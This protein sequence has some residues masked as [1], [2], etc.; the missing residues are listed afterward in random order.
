MSNLRPFQVVLLA[1]FAIM[2][3]GATILL[4]SFQA[5]SSQEALVYGSSVSV[6]GTL[7]REVMRD[8]FDEITGQV[9]AF[10]VV[11]YTQVS[12]SQFHGELINAIADGNSPDLILLSSEDIVKFR[13]KI[14]AIPYETIPLRTILDTYVDGADIFAFDE[15][16]YSVPFAVDPLVQYWNR[17]MFAS[18]QLA[19]PPVSW[20]EVANTVVPQITVKD[21]NRNVAKSGLAFGEYRNV[22]NAKEILM[23]LAMQSG[24]RMTTYK[25]YEYFIQLN[26]PI[27][28]G[29]R[30]PFYATLEFFTDFSNSNSPRY[31][32]NRAM[33]IDRNVF[34]S[35][36]LAL[37][38]GFGSEYA[39]IASKNPNL[40]FDI[41]QVPQ[42]K[43]ATIKRTY[44]S[45]YGFAILKASGN[46]QGAFAAL[47]TMQQQQFA[48]SLAYRLDMSSSRR[49]TIAIGSSDPIKQTI[50]HSALIARGWLDP[51]TAA[52]DTIFLQMIE[53]IVSNRL[54][55]GSAASDAI[56]RLSLTY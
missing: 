1:V 46:S 16:V 43:S 17:D 19:T 31:S 32:W 28:S 50:M 4:A 30:D 12:E 2:G 52:S 53:D 29:A 41:T 23:M 42:G 10:D 54:Q 3:V 13:S 6:W 20:E 47:Q 26:T 35:G 34:L 21:N 9:E 37:Y 7:D 22:V 18:N 8:F 38:Y 44:G 56:S 11:S 36:D 15:G 51:D 49:A 33:P 27:Q 24:S 14:I 5:S 25:D 40:N 55:F 48:D 39:D 45:F